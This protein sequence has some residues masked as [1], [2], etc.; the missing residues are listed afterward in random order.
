MDNHVH[1]PV[2]AHMNQIL[3]RYNKSLYINFF[4][5]GRDF[6]TIKPTFYKKRE[7]NTLLFRK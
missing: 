2:F 7:R 5:E 4:R 1:S 6:L 3:I